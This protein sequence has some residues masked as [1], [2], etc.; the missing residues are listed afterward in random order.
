MT[1]SN[2]LFGL[3]QCYSEQGVCYFRDYSFNP[4]FLLII[5]T[6]L[7]EIILLLIFLVSYIIFYQIWRKDVRKKI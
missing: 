4:I 2:H 6:C 5:Y 1:I 7:T 3:I